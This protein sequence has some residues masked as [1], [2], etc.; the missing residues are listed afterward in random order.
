MIIN[1]TRLDTNKLIFKIHIRDRE[2]I[3]KKKNISQN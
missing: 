3:E 1:L 2:K